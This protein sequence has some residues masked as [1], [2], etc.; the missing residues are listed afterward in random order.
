ME[1]EIIK[2]DDCCDLAY[3]IETLYNIQSIS[4]AKKRKVGA[5]LVD[6]N[7]MHIL[8]SG[9]NHNQ[10]AI[11]K[12]CENDEGDT[13]DTVI[14]AEADCIMSTC[15]DPSLMQCINDECDNIAMFVTFSPCIECSKLI[16]QFGKIKTLFIMEEHEINFRKCNIK[17]SL[18]PLELL[19]SN[20]IDIYFYDKINNQFIKY[21]S[22]LLN[23]KFGVY[24]SADLDGFM[25][26]YFMEK[27]LVSKENMFGY[28]YEKDSDWKNINLDNSN[29]PVTFYF[30]DIS[31]DIDWLV[32]NIN[33][34]KSG[35]LKLI[36]LDH[37]KSILND[38][39]S[40][41]EL[42]DLTSENIDIR[43]SLSYENLSGCEVV[44]KYLQQEKNIE[45]FSEKVYKLSNIIGTYD[46]W[47]FNEPNFEYGM[48]TKNK[49]YLLNLI[50]YL[51]FTYH[52]KNSFITFVD[53]LTDDEFDNLSNIGKIIVNNLKNQQAHKISS[54]LFIKMSDKDFMIITEDSSAAFYTES[55]IKDYHKKFQNDKYEFSDNLN[56]LY[57][58]YSTKFDKNT[59]NFSVRSYINDETSKYITTAKKFTKKFGGG[60]HE[61]AAG[62]KL[63]IDDG[64]KILTNFL[65]E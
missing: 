17:G 13:F 21:K 63:S 34:L 10:L 65:K 40:I 49:D 57:I 55:L 5:I 18:S 20:N 39:N 24:H 52:D 54:G 16:L 38:I 46:T 9:Y 45:I 23:D 53:N 8:S 50:T 51:K 19:I 64:Y 35:K 4:I 56:Y 61:H 47:R 2:V 42:N 27:Y 22:N 29:K 37:H 62:F 3:F 41:M 43:L 31:P 14:H 59:I 15:K 26:A 33:Y 11:N 6:Y 60:G 7:R 58:T 12:F 25:S 44:C 1:Q 36:I 30:G 32:K 48:Y 28:N